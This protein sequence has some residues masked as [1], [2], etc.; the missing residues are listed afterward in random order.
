MELSIHRKN[1]RAIT[2]IMVVAC[3]FCLIPLSIVMASALT[4]PTIGMNGVNNSSLTVGRNALDD[5]TRLLDNDAADWHISPS[6]SVYPIM[7][8]VPFVFL[9]VALLLLIQMALSEDKSI[10]NLIYAAILIIIALS[11]LSG[12]QFSINSLLGG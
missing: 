6:D 8:L 7:I 1:Y 4:D 5:S 10:K 12:I 11:M 9:V 2:I 3:V